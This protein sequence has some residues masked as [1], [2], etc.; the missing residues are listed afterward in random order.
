MLALS[1]GSLLFLGPLNL[2]LPHWMKAKCPIGRRP[3]SPNY[4]MWRTLLVVGAITE[5][6]CGMLESFSQNPLGFIWG[7][8]RFPDKAVSHSPRNALY[9][10]ENGKVA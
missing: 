4:M 3:E 10:K 7:E 9:N 2:F 8:T 1:F 5:R 6:L